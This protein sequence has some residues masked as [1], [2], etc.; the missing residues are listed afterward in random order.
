MGTLHFIMG[1]RKNCRSEIL[2][3]MRAST[4]VSVFAHTGNFGC[5]CADVVTGYVNVT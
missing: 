4:Y 5:N 2:L 1:Q 3:K